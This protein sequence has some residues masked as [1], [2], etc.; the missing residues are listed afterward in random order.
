[1]YSCTGDPSF[2][3][4]HPDRRVLLFRPQQQLYVSALCCLVA[5][6]S[7]T[8][9]SELLRFHIQLQLHTRPRPRW[10]SVV[11]RFLAKEL[12]SHLLARTVFLPAGLCRSFLTALPRQLRGPDS[13]A[14]LHLERFCGAGCGARLRWLCRFHGISDT[15]VS[16]LAVYPA[17][18]FRQTVFSTTMSSI[19]ALSIRRCVC[20]LIT[21]CAQRNSCRVSS[22]RSI[23]SAATRGLGSPMLQSPSW[24]ASQTSLDSEPCSAPMSDFFHALAT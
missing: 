20:P 5:Q 23:G 15:P 16:S 9:R 12:S 22:L 11:F 8:P 2:F 7:A 1:M 21:S 14:P 18:D 6:R 17:S 19:S 3:S 24:L 4:S 10:I 13:V